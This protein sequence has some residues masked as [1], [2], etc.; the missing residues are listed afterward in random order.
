MARPGPT[1][2][3]LPFFARISPFFGPTPGRLRAQGL[4]AHGLARPGATLPIPAAP[5]VWAPGSVGAAGGGR[6]GSASRM[7]LPGVL[8][9]GIAVISGLVTRAV[10]M[11]VVLRPALAR[12]RFDP[13]GTIADPVAG[14]GQQEPLPQLLGGRRWGGQ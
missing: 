10:Q 7:A 14:D 2:P 13:V 11:R 4:V 12:P 5:P 1:F 3:T 8:S 6:K 9:L